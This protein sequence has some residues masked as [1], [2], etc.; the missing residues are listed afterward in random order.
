M[1]KIEC[2]FLGQKGFAALSGMIEHGLGNYIVAVI[3]G[4]DP[5]IHKDYYTEMVAIC[6]ENNI[7]IFDR[8]G[9]TP[10]GDV[11]MRCAVGWKWMIQGCDRLVTI[12]DSLLPK[13]RGFLP[14]VTMLIN[15][16]RKIGATAILASDEFDK[17]PILMQVCRDIDYPIKVHHAIDRVCECYAEIL[18]SLCKVFLSTGSMPD[19][20]EQDESQATYSLWRDEH[21]YFVDWHLSA[22]QIK[23]FIDSVGYPYLG[24]KAYCNGQLMTLLDAEVIEDFTIVNRTVGKVIML[25]NGCPCV[26]CGQGLLKVTQLQDEQGNSV[27]PFNKLRVQFGKISS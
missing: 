2:Y 21:D 6:Q 7:P 20:K 25:K 23:R 1:L 26:V 27:L 9:Y 19:A 22:A 15:G 3:V 5:Y 14:L 11:S 24:A 17:G 18:V 12:H 8:Q 4:R 16:E 13:Y 10:V